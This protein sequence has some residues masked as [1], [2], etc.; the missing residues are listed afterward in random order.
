MPSTLT[1]RLYGLSTSVAVKAPC[2]VATTA[3]IVLSG[4]QT[5]D[6]VALAVRDRVLVKDQPNEIDNGI[7][8]AQTG[9]WV[10]SAD[11]NGTLDAVGGT[12]VKVNEGS[13]NAN[14][15][16]T[17]EGDG[18]LDIGLD[19]M[20]FTGS[21]GNID[22]QA[23]LA[24]P[25]GAGLIGWNRNLPG[26]QTISL[27]DFLA[28]GT[29]LV[30]QEFGAKGDGVTDDTAAMQA[31]ADAAIAQGRPIF[32]PPGTY[33]ITSSIIMRPNSTLPFSTV[34]SPC[35]QIIGAGMATTFF[36]WRGSNSALLD[37][38]SGV[39]H[40]TTRRF[41]VGGRLQGFAIRRGGASTNG[42]GIRLRAIYNMRVSDIFIWGLSGSGIVDV[43]TVGDGDGNNC[44]RYENVRI[45]YCK[46][47]GFDAKP[48]VGANET[49]FIVFDHV[50]IQGCGEVDGAFPPTSGGMR[51]KGQILAI[52]N[53]AFEISRNVDLYIPGESGQSNGVFISNTA[54][55]GIP[56]YKIIL[57][58]MDNFYCVNSHF[59]CS[60]DGTA[61]SGGKCEYGLYSDN[62]GYAPNR[63]VVFENLNVR[64]PSF[65][66][67]F[68][69]FK[70]ISG[71]TQQSDYLQVRN[72]TWQDFGHP[73]Q[74]KFEGVVFPPVPRQA[75]FSL[76]ANTITLAPSTIP[77]EEGG[78][79]FPLK[80]RTVA[81]GSHV[82]DGEVVAYSVPALGLTL[83]T[84][85]LSDGTYYVYLYDNNNITQ[86]GISA[87]APAI[88]D[89]TS[90]LLV[91]NDAK[92][93]IYVCKAVISGG[94]LVTQNWVNAEYN[95]Q[96][97]GYLW[98]NSAGKLYLKASHIAPTSDTDGV[99]VGTQT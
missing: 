57:A 60:D 87:Q 28:A 47:W 72:V 53:S 45:Y 93:W 86:L 92:G 30:P 83:S 91:R 36:D 34:F 99:V 4:L 49:S 29:F 63:Y 51:Y 23:A 38:E 24:G 2:R 79:G 18:P 48:A 15:F 25:S 67:T 42:D 68:V 17:L 19:E 69:A 61:G 13:L 43:C 7:W 59:Y 16:W 11:F 21:S 54:F 89:T 31:C 26:T 80:L 82:E 70:Q 44:N 66:D 71:F 90:R 73:G 1:D 84:D 27:L 77:G 88:D 3:S 46:I 37:I 98:V 33:L 39:D 95:R 41:A 9:A 55:E 40:T 14:S 62:T 32:V 12:L 81:G 64:A 6:G 94:A 75:K 10:R 52:H 96:L 85:G 65:N 22:L 50:F 35:P 97:G 5:I 20:V 58:G 74:K 76:A 8:L 56:K 78:S